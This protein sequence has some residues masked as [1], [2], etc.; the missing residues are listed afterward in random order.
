MVGGQVAKRAGF[1][2]ETAGMVMEGPDEKQGDK[3][4]S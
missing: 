1:I 4:K 3:R 2:I